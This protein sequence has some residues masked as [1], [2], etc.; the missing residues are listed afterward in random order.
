MQATREAS[1]LTAKTGEL[2][3]GS[4]KIRYLTIINAMKLG[5]GCGAAA[6]CYVH[7]PRSNVKVSEYQ[8]KISSCIFD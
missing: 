5:D 1:V 8:Q 4:W 7:C 6:S 2:G 3:I